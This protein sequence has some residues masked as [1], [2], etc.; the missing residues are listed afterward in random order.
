MVKPFQAIT[1]SKSSHTRH[2]RSLTNDSPL[3]KFY[4]FKKIREERCKE[5]SS[6]GKVIKSLKLEQENEKTERKRII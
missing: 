3:N 6:G 5:Q 1:Q 4:A 2:S